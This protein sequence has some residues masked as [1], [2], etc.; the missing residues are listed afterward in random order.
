MLGGHVRLQPLFQM[1][2]LAL[3]S[4]AHGLVQLLLGGQTEAVRVLDLNRMRFARLLEDETAGVD[5]CKCLAVPLGLRRQ[6]RPVESRSGS[7]VVE[8]LNGTL[9]VELLLELGHHLE[10]VFALVVG[11]RQLPTLH[12]DL[13]RL[14]DVLGDVEVHFGGVAQELLDL[15]DFGQTV[16]R[17][18]PV[19]FS[20]TRDV[21]RTPV[22]RMRD[23][24][25][26][27]SVRM[28]PRLHHHLFEVSVGG[29]QEI[30]FGHV[31]GRRVQIRII[32][33][34]SRI[35]HFELDLS[36]LSTKLDGVL[37]ILRGS[38]KV[39]RSFAH[40]LVL[41]R[42]AASMA[43]VDVL[44][45]RRRCN[46]GIRVEARQVDV[47]R[48]LS[49]SGVLRINSVFTDLELPFAIRPLRSRIERFELFLGRVKLVIDHLIL[50]VVNHLT[51]VPEGPETLSNREFR[52]LSR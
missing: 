52:L 41:D 23:G 19:V 28:K 17:V 12:V 9:L 37:D 49:L 20:S 40:G 38:L 15:V 34:R 6:K 1:H 14:F 48:F 13:V 21:F 33:L 8:A 39:R 29:L 45:H 51:V 25:E 10:H 31:P 7:V 46:G 27:S 18:Q 35:I 11:P 36:P 4:I 24:V 26:L 44:D 43:I 32:V 16:L 50:L 47:P 22:G 3:L 2:K 5:I 42:L 30:D